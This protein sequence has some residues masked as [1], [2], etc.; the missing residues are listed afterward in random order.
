MVEKK[1]N[2]VKLYGGYS[3][4]AENLLIKEKI[5]TSTKNV[6]PKPT[7][8]IFLLARYIPNFPHIITVKTGNS[9]SGASPT[10]VGSSTVCIGRSTALVS[11]SKVSTYDR[12]LVR[13]ALSLNQ[14]T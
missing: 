14:L 5:P 9:V 8:E 13:A 11:D 3:F 12:P 7:T 6:F 1:K 10:I 2:N 4:L